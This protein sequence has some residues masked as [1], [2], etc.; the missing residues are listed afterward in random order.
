LLGSTDGSLPYSVICD[1]SNNPASRT[2]LG[3]VQSDAQVQYQAINEK[4]I[5]NI[6]G[7]QTVQVQVQSVPSASGALA[8]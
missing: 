4:F 8:P 5:V 7:G 3:Y 2:G 1:V 6:E